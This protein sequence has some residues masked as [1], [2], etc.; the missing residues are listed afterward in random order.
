MSSKKRRV[1]TNDIQ[2]VESTKGKISTISYIK[3]KTIN[4]SLFVKSIKR[5]TIT[6][7]FGCAGTGKSLIALHEAV[8]LINS[9]SSEI[10]KI[11]YIRANVSMSQEKD[12]GF[13]PGG[14]IEKILPLAYPV[15]DNLIEFI[16]EGTAKYLIES[17]RIEILPVSMV[18]GRS[19]KNA[20]VIVDEAQNCIGSTIKALLTRISQNSKM[21]LI[22]DIKQCDL[23]IKYGLNNGLLDAVHRLQGV[24]DVGIVQ[25]NRQDIQR[26]T[27]I[28]HILERYE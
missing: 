23:D 19:F 11:F 14:L 5:N 18:R 17:G 20:I 25:F 9:E 16:E 26:H 1:E 3:P 15:L 2:P 28:S 21:I 24:E 10:N 4:Q 8:K 27:I 13:L 7:G 22:G 12:L 6:I